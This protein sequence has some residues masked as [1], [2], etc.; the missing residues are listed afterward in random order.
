MHPSG[1]LQHDLDL[2]LDLEPLVLIRLACPQTCKSAG[3]GAS[4]RGGASVEDVRGSVEQSVMGL[5]G[6]LVQQTS[7]ERAAKKA[8][9]HATHDSSGPAQGAANHIQ[10]MREALHGTHA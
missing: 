7:V 1:S 5:W 2:E 3:G 4:V 8:R 10:I 6:L 9:E